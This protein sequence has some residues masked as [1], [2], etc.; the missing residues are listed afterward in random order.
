VL[1]ANKIAMQFRDL[2]RHFKRSAEREERSLLHIG[3]AVALLISGAAF[4][5]IALLAISRPTEPAANSA[6]PAAENAVFSPP[7]MSAIPAGPAGDAIRRGQAIF[8]DPGTHASAFVGNVLACKNCHLDSGRRPD[9]SPMWS[10]WTSYPQF[11]KKTNS[12]NTMEDRIMGCFLYSMNAPASS[13]GGPPPAGSD[14]Y[15]DLE[16]Y[17]YWLATGA[18]TAG[19]L[20]GSGYPELQLTS[21]G[22]DPQRGAP[23][24][25]QKCSGCHGSDGQGAIQPDG[26]VVY[27][28]LWGGKSYNWGAGMARVDLAARFIKANMPFDQPGT[29]SDQEAWDIAAYFDSQERPRDPRQVGSIAANAKTNFADQLSYYGKVVNGKLLGGGVPAAR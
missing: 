22:Y 5:G 6:G 14:V 21:L 15:R 16:A 11:R 4:G 2:V 7:P 23:L 10:A 28:P 12:I 27:P 24:Y 3:S 1:L 13:S 19:K 29:L 17:F 8:D 18:P 20:A 26:T 25:E 9:S